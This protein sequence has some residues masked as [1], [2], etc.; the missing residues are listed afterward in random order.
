MWLHAQ[1]IDYASDRLDIVAIQTGR[2]IAMGKKLR[3][4]FRDVIR[5]HHY[6]YRTGETYWKWVKRFIRF[7]A[8]RHP[9][10]MQVDEIRSFLT[11]LATKGR[12]SASTQ[13]Q[14]LS[15]LLFLYKKVLKI[16]L[17]YASSFVSHSPS[18]E[19]LRYPYRA[20]VTRSR[21]RQDYPD[22]YTCSATR[23]PRGTQPTGYRLAI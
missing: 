15:A 5:T 18:S 14:A 9:R 12:V 17:P 7:H 8:N 10:S 6:S 19:W 3:D 16:K 21:Q 23:R 11:Y 22:L 1:A 2:I 20:G 13:N 4:E